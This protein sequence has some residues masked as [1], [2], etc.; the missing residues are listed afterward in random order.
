MEIKTITSRSNPLIIESAKLSDRKYRDKSGR[1]FFE[2]RKLFLDAAAAGVELCEIF[3]TEE[4]LA[5]Y[6]N[7]L[8]NY[9]VNAVSRPVFEK[10]CTEKSPQGIICI[11]KHL[12]NYHKFITIYNGGGDAD[13]DPCAHRMMVCGMQDPGNL[14]TVIRSA[15]AL[16]VSELILDGRCADLYH[17]RTVRAAMGALFRQRITVC[18]DA[19]Q[20]I[21]ALQQRGCRLLAA[22]LTPDAVRLDRMALTPECCFIIGNEGHGLDPEILSAADGSVLIPMREGSESLNASAAAAVLLWH[23]FAQYPQ[24]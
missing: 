10:I 7:E 23:R 22:A 20:T 15:C 11:A 2:G 13:F 17:P 18:G 21:R 16:G 9:R 24:F 8:E 6:G 14:G 1:F 12:D 5:E 4:Y 19:V 3:V